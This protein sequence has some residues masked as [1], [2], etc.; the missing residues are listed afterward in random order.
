MSTII[1]TIQEIVRAEMRR[2]RVAELGLVEA[3]Y[4]HSGDGDNDNYACDV[5]LK[6][7]GLLLKRVPTA[8]GHIGTAAIPN[9]SDLVLL[10]FDKGDINQGIIIG[11]LYNEKERPP[12]NNPDEVIFRLPLAE[13]DDKT[14]KA[15]IRNIQANSEPR[16]MIFEMP[17]KI[18]VRVT[19]GTVRATAGKTEMKLDQPD[20]SGGTV[21]VIAGRTKITMNQDGDVVIEAAGA[22]SLKATRDLTLEGMNV[23]IKGQVNT[24][25]E[26]GA[27]A[28]LKA[29]AGATVNGGATTTVQGAMVSVKGMVSFSP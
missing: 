5:R 3:V 20:G 12:L 15:A 24:E 13:A 16:E 6:N 2:V 25:I 28:T 18:T 1:N 26:A 9:V 21:T 23:S 10:T 8:T 14:I 22:M 27:Q 17:P 7:S 11:R 4:P 19:D 29:N